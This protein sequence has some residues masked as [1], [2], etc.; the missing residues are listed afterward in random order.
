MHRTL[1]IITSLAIVSAIG[2][3]GCSSSP[4]APACNPDPS[5]AND[6]IPV[7]E[8]SCTLSSVC[9]GQQNNTAEES[10]YLGD[11][12]TNTPTTITAAYNTMVN[13]TAKENP[14][15]KIVKPG[16][17]ANSYLWN[18]VSL[19]QDDLNTKLGAQCKMAAMMCTPTCSASMPC[20]AT[21]P[22]LSSTL[23]PKFQC[24]I[25]NWIQNGAKNN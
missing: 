24:T 21:M 12:M 17:P 1:A 23:D 4:A 13:V 3:A 8:M 7:F 14:Q 25:Q 19:S 10:L 5:F 2:A 16:D 9:H 6:V 22:Y 18:K 11:N 15:M 20:G